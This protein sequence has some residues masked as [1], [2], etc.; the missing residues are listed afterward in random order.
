M[1]ELTK[2]ATDKFIEV[3]GIRLHYNEAGSGP[4]LLG[5]HGGG[6]GASAWGGLKYPLPELAK[7]ARV[8]LLDLPNFGDSQKH[9]K[10]DGQTPDRFLAGLIGDLLDALGIDE[11]ISFYT[12]SGGLENPER[13]HR[14][15]VQAYSPG[16][17]PKPGGA[18]INSTKAFAENPT[19]ETMAEIFKLMTT[20]SYPGYDDALELRW[21]AASA[22]GHIES[23]AEFA[24]L[25]KNSDFVKEIDSLAAE[26]LFVWGA[27]DQIVPIERALLALATIPSASAHIFGGTGHLVPFERPDEFARLVID[28]ITE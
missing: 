12:S 7:H 9:V 20:P 4:V 17:L 25:G 2:E 15:I 19:R 18:G 26:V 22:P 5:T 8:I 16:M 13:V 24:T 6:P 21:K 28:F 10:S 1:P 14:L 23:R 11:S 3:N 27:D